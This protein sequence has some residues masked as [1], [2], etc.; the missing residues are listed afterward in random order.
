MHEFVSPKMMISEFKGELKT[1]IC[2]FRLIKIV[3]ECNIRLIQL[4]SNLDKTNLKGLNSKYVI[5]R[6]MLQ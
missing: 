3:I 5:S 2:L 1:K 4:Q 6:N